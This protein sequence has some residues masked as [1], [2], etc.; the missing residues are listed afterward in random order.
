MGLSLV[1]LLLLGLVLIAP[2]VA[3]LYLAI[4]LPRRTPR[5]PAG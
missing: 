3:G 4:V 1:F 5:P 2:V